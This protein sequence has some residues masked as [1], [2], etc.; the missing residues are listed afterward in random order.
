[1]STAI[2][3]CA[4]SSLYRCYGCAVLASF[5]PSC[6]YANMSDVDLSRYG[7]DVWELAGAGLDGRPRP[8]VLERVTAALVEAVV[9]ERIILY[10]SGA[11]GE[12]TP[13]SDI[14]L[15]LVLETDDP[16]RVEELA[17][18]S[19]SDETC[20]LQLSVATEADLAARAHKPYDM[21][22]AALDDGVT[23]HDVRPP[24]E[25]VAGPR[26]GQVSADE[27]FRDARAWLEAAAGWLSLTEDPTRFRSVVCE[28]SERIVRIGLKAAAIASGGCHHSQRTIA[29]LRLE[30]ERLGVDPCVD[31]DLAAELDGYKDYCVLDSDIE[32][33]TCERV[34]LAARCVLAR[35]AA[36]V[37]TM[38]E[39]LAQ[40]TAAAA[41]APPR[42]RRVCS[43]SVRLRR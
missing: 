34:K 31:A 21:L 24:G 38:E 5:A 1:M 25:R 9:P 28:Q 43:R 14:D 6:E 32:V 29:A 17:R 41:R 23:L 20:A 10:G 4:I 36:V 30:V 22:Y 35:A 7:P 2:S 42:V 3:S 19:V 40:D 18:E 39:T 12:M 27:R 11:R 13:E 33:A 37:E 15:L 16:E 8:D 26:R